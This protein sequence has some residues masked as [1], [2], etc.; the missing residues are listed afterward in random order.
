[1]KYLYVF[2]FA[3]FIWGCK[4]ATYKIEEVEEVVVEPEKTAAVIDTSATDNKSEIK[5]DLQQIK[6]S[7]NKFT[8]KK[9]ISKVYAI[10]IGA[11]ID[12]KNASVFKSD[13][14]KKINT[15]IYYKNINGLYKV[16]VGN[17]N[18]R[19][20]A[21]SLLKSV[22]ESGYSDSFMVELTYVTDK[23]K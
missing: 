17:I 14:E 15:E 3:L 6:E 20:E 7:D 2:I 21:D 1:L 4:S 13:A 12:E 18:T 9:I 5:E 10:Q 11:F 19:E 16:R 8:D 23:D 22:M